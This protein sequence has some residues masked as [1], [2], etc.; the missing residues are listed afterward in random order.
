VT[1]AVEGGVD[2]EG[3]GADFF[4]EGAQMVLIHRKLQDSSGV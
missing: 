4:K 2:V 1:Q 3:S